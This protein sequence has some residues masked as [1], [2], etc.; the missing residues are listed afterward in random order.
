MQLINQI[1]AHSHATN[2]ILSGV[3]SSGLIIYLVDKL[4]GK[5]EL[6]PDV[7]CPISLTAEFAVGIINSYSFI[8]SS[9]LPNQKA[10]F[11]I[12]STAIISSPFLSEVIKKVPVEEA[13]Q[14]EI[15]YKILDFAL[16]VNKVFTIS[17][18][19]IAISK[20]ISPNNDFA[21]GVLC[22]TV[23]VTSIASNWKLFHSLFQEQET[24]NGD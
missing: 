22:T 20:A 18:S 15:F 21:A 6:E 1:A 4:A 24:D 11:W 13:T 3:S 5:Y 9:L 10:L 7:A 14:K 2:L 17:I 19:S 8:S 16:V 23:G 12:I